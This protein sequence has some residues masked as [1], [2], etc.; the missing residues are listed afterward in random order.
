MNAPTDRAAWLA[1]RRLGIGGSDVAAMLGLSPYKSPYQLW[2][3]KT[4]RSDDAPVDADAEERMH[5]GNVL[6]QVVAQEYTERTRNRVQRILSQLQHPQCGIALANIDRAIVTPGSKARWDN[7]SGRVLGADGVL[8]CKTAHAMALNGSEWGDAGTD[9]VPQAY[10]LQV[11]W[12]LGITGLPRGDLA[13]LF[14]GQR[15]RIYTMQADAAIFDGLLTE[16]D[17]WWREHVVADTP[18]QPRTEDE[19]RQR[20]SQH[21]EGRD[22]I[23]DADTAQLVAELIDLK[24]D[25]AVMERREQVLRDHITCAFEDAEAITYA[26]RRLATWKAN[27]PSARTD[28]K[29]AA[30]DLRDLLP[31]DVA[32]PYVERHTITT[33]GARVL[34]LATTKE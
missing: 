18:P 2:L 22:R 28:W 19:A 12:Y 15:F 1:Q 10:W 14:G 32:D 21:I 9:Q 8:E 5:F 17:R 4:G 26:G 34:R 7:A 31:A 6:E 3:D 27:K 24:A 16:A 25:L 11:Q 13:V 20:W 30:R 29:A 33:P 23:V